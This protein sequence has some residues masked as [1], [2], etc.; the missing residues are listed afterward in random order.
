[1]QTL[2]RLEIDDFQGAVLTAD[3]GAYEAARRVENGRFYGARPSVILRPRGPAD[4]AAAIAFARRSGL[5]LAVRSGGHSTAGHSA[6]DGGIVLDMRGIDAIDIDARTDTVWVGGGALA[7]DVVRDAFTVGRTVPFGDT[8]SV[9][10]AGITLGGGSGWLSRLFGLTIDSLLA[11]EVV[12][13]DGR[14]LTASADEHRD[15]FWAVRGG[16]GNFGVVTRLR[17]QLRPIDEVL[18]GTITL[19]ATHDVLR[20]LVPTLLAAPDE[21]TAMPNIMLGPAVEGAAPG[22]R[23][24]LT[25]YVPICW[26]GSRAAGERA[27]APL[28]ALGPVIDDS[29]TAMPYPAVYGGDGEAGP[30]EAGA[31]T[32]VERDGDAS[33]A[34]DDGGWAFRSVYLDDLDDAVIETIERQLAATSSSE[35]LA[36][37]RVLGGAVARTPGDA[38][39]F[40]WRDKA[41]ILIVIANDADS[42]DPAGTESWIDTFATELRRH[43]EGAYPNFMGAVGDDAVRLAYPRATFARLRAVKRRYDPDDIFRAAYHIRPA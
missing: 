5:A 10:V 26:S 38:T 37:L 35:A 12:T 34:V 16:G 15:L 6:G 27:L 7:G 18:F 17:F 24:D 28:R 22:A 36:H 20:R 14:L 29:I 19:P 42:S 30:G 32:D 1:M 40:G 2:P 25:V 43:G 8:A 41:V 11:V 31:A 3:D 9:G 4:V 39:A 33:A 21:L 23:G 13:A